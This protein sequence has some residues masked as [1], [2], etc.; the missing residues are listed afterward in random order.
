M[1][2]IE[3]GHARPGGA[4]ADSTRGAGGAAP[5]EAQRGATGGATRAQHDD[6]RNDDGAPSPGA[7]P[8][9]RCHT[10]RRR[11]APLLTRTRAAWGACRLTG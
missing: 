1:V 2:D 9:V 11:H 6:D 7:A 8:Q 3:L 10:R 5:N 4:V